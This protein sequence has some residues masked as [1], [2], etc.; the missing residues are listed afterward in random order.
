MPFILNLPAPFITPA[1]VIN[2]ATDFA[3]FFAAKGKPAT[4]WA[5]GVELELFGFTR[6]TLERIG[7]G[8]IQTLFEGFADQTTSRV[9]ENG[10]ITEAELSR[11]A[12]PRRRRAAAPQSGDAAASR[13]P[14]AS[15]SAQGRMTLEPG[16]QVE[17]SGAP[18][19]SLVEVERGLR[20]YIN[21][22]AEIAASQNIV[23]IALGFDP[24]R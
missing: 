15:A 14:F 4:A 6:D 23:F 2:T 9:I 7:S 19:R 13:L 10:Q 20:Q 16:G 5:V 11:S 3:R 18:H 22:L 12:P 1:E 21:R 8:H 24:L 17:F